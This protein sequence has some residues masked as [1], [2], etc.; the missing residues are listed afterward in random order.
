MI[1]KKNDEPRGKVTKSHRG[2][3]S[4]EINKKTIRI[5][6]GLIIAAIICFLFYNFIVQPYIRDF[7]SFWIGI[8]FLAF[9]IVVFVIVVRVSIKIHISMS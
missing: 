1:Q 2:T 4:R 8:G 6:V 3:T 9:C 7:I 5:V